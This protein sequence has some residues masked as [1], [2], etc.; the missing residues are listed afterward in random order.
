MT[1]YEIWEWKS[2][3]DSYLHVYFLITRNIIQLQCLFSQK[4]PTLQDQQDSQTHQIKSFKFL[5]HEGGV[6]PSCCTRRGH[7]F[8][9]WFGAAKSFL[10]NIIYVGA[11]FAL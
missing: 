5:T 4:N 3:D 11:A 9:T 10:R 7:H 8:K 2:G 1:E 6:A